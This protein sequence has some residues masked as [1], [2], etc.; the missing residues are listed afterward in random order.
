[1]RKYLSESTNPIQLLDFGGFKVF[2]DAT[3]DVNILISEKQKNKDKA[4]AC[5]INKDFN[6]LLDLNQYFKKSKIDFK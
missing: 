6:E 1:L 4:K 5:I 2:K 3:V